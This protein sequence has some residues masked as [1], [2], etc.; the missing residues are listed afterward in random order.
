MSEQSA[1]L[2]L[3]VMRVPRLSSSAFTNDL[4]GL[5]HH[6][7]QQ[8]RAIREHV[9]AGGRAVLVDG[10][11]ELG[12]YELAEPPPAST[13]VADT[14]RLVPIEKKKPEAH[15]YPYLLVVPMSMPA[16]EGGSPRFSCCYQTI[17]AGHADVCTED[18][19]RKVIEDALARAHI[20][21][22]R[23]I[24]SPSVAASAVVQVAPV[25]RNTL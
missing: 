20:V 17:E 7:E 18:R 16:S 14:I 24:A 8:L 25:N 11:R 12:Q 9:L 13:S 1:A 2:T 23:L 5:A 6:L 22:E 15:G 3:G 21:S 4:L 19:R 10:D